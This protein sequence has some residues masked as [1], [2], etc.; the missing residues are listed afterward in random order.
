MKEPRFFVEPTED[1]PVGAGLTQDS[2]VKSNP[3]RHPELRRYMAKWFSPRTI[4]EL[5][6]VVTKFCDDLL[7][8]V[9][10]RREFDLVQEYALPLAVKVIAYILGVPDTYHARFQEL[11]D[12][13]ARMLDPFLTTEQTREGRAASAEMLDY[14]RELYD[15]RRRDPGDD[16]LS[17]LLVAGDDDKKLTQLELLANAQFVLLAGYETTVGMLGSGVNMLVDRPECWRAMRDDDALVPNVIE[18]TLRLESPVQMVLR[19]AQHDVDF[20]GQHVPAGTRV[21]AVLAAAN[22]D[23]AMFPDPARFDPWRDNANRQLSFVVG[24]HH[25]LGSALARMEGAIA[26]RALLARMPEIHRAGPPVR[27]PN[28]IARGLT[29]LPLAVTTR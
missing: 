4:E 1:D 17:A 3:P 14:F 6:V 11:G 2:I 5:D 22:R 21:L 24:P 12:A 8:P 7:D 10:A 27:R 9:M 13:A 18:E 28:F 29:N 16:L 23:P 19:R 20:L 26:L 25:C 15:E